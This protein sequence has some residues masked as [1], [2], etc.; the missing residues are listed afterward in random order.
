[1]L[2][3]VIIGA[4]SPLWFIAAYALCQALLPFL[5]RM[6]TV[7]PKRTVLVLLAGVIVVDAIRYAHR[8]RR[9]SAS[10]WVC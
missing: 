10:G 4:G 7:A 9:G 2:D 8:P 3:G 5:A 1:M 6:H